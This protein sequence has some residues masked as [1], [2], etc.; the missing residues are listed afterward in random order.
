MNTQLLNATNPDDIELAASFL[1][2]GKIV[3][4]ATETVYGLGAN[5]LNEDAVAKIF[6][7]K[8]R[9]N[10]NPLIV[11]VHDVSA[12]WSLWNEDF[13]AQDAEIKDKIVKLSEAFWP[14]PLSIICEKSAKVS[15]AVSAG[16]K[17]V[18]VRVPKPL[19]SR[20]LI[21]KSGVPIVAPSA[22]LH[23][24]PSP[25]TAAHVLLTLGGKIDAILDDGACEFG[26][27]S[28]VI[29]ISA[30]PPL[31]LRSGA[32][33]LEQIQAIIPQAR[34]AR[35][36]DSKQASPGLQ[37]KHY[38]PLLAKAYLCSKAKISTLWFSATSLIVT[39]ST[40]ANIY[41]QQGAR[42]QGFTEILPDDPAG[43]AHALYRAFYAAEEHPAEDLAIEKP[44]EDPAWEPVLDK[45]KR[46]TFNG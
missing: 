38:A 2:A 15:D 17:K 44:A 8:K 20:Q 21:E 22:N 42:T 25:T 3:A 18:A 9:P 12:A 7:A 35:A 19:V 39:Q 36:D 30:Q 40:Y 32:I 43:F 45:L 33:S 1:A 11:H 26:I 14:G 5:A 16:S 37:K 41:S 6:S 10:F 31:I 29:D 13:L 28:T 46:A 34:L 4:F 27:E 23:M 24:R